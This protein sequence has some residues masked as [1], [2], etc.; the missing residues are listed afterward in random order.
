MSSANCACKPSTEYPFHCHC[1]DSVYSYKLK[2]PA[3]HQACVRIFAINSDVIC[4]IGI[5][6]GICP[7]GP[8]IAPALPG[9]SCRK[10]RIYCRTKKEQWFPYK[11]VVCC[12]HETGQQV[13]RPWLLTPHGDCEIKLRCGTYRFVAYDANHD[14]V[15]PD[16]CDIVM[17]AQIEAI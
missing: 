16:P 8:I 11:E 13:I 17:Q 10:P 3:Q 6:Q 2:V 5:E 7:V 9:A 4:G 12:D 15:I 1:T 14:P